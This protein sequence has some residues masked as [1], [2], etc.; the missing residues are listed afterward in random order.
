MHLSDFF[1]LLAEGLPGTRSEEARL[2]IEFWALLK[3]YKYGLRLRRLAESIPWYL[4]LHRT[5]I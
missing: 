3:V 5:C 4:Y 2:G 1:G